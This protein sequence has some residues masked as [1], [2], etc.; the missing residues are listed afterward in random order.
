MANT[1]INVSKNGKTTLATA[2]KYCDRNIDVNVSVAG[3][4]TQFTNLYDPASV[5]IGSFVSVSSNVVSYTS[6]AYVNRIKFP[7]HHKA[8][9]PVQIRIRGIGFVRSYMAIVL[10]NADG[11]TRNNHAYAKENEVSIDE[12]GDAV[13]TFPSGSLVNNEW[14]FVELNFQYD[15][16]DKS[17]VAK[18]GA[19]ITINEPIGNGGVA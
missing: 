14:Y 3:S 11:T 4:P 12:Y 2:G 18:A 5:V 17:T 8:G 10:F 9:E 15:F 1:Q 7:Y 6:N 13:Y 16:V 19:I